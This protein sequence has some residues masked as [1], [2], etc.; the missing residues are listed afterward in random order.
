MQSHINELQDI[1]RK[2]VRQVLEWSEVRFKRITMSHDASDNP[3]E[4]YGANGKI[5]YRKEG[6]TG[7]ELGGS[8]QSLWEVSDVDAIRPNPLKKV[9]VAGKDVKDVWWIWGHDIGTNSDKELEFH[10][11]QGG[12]GESSGLH[13][14]W[15]EL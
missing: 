13:L 14:D 5:Y 11:L 10:F 15:G 4:V 3:A 2:I 8:E 9:D 1:V 12:G 7:V 6:G